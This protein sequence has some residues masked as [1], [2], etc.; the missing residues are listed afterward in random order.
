MTKAE[1]IEKMAKEAKISKAAAGKAL[2]SFMDDMALGW[3]DRAERREMQ[4]D[5]GFLAMSIAKQL[6]VAIVLSRVERGDL[7]LTGRVADVIP[8]FASHPETRDC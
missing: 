1:L 8:E 5:S 2:D 7:S 6:T 4:Q 3:S